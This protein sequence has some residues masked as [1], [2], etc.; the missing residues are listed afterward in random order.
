MKPDQAVKIVPLEYEPSKKSKDELIDELVKE[1]VTLTP[2]QQ[3][4]VDQYIHFMN[5]LKD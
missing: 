4:A 2:E 3:N 1:Y 5:S